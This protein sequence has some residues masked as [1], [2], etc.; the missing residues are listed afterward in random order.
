M[1]RLTP[2][3]E[4]V[5]ELIWQ[6][7]P[8]TP[9]DVQAMYTRPIPNINTVAGAFQS[10][11]RKGYLTHEKKGRGYLYI[12]MIEQKDYGKRRFPLGYAEM[13]YVVLLLVGTVAFAQSGVREKVQ[14]VVNQVV[15]KWEVEEPVTVEE[16]QEVVP[17]PSAEKVEPETE[18]E[19][20]DDTVYE[21]VDQY[22]TFP[23]GEEALLNLL[24]TELRYPPLAMACG[25]SGRIFVSFVIEKDGSVSSPAIYR[26]GAQS[27]YEV[28]GEAV[29]E[30]VESYTPKEG[31]EQYIT[32][33][34][35]ESAR[36]ALE[37]EVLRVVL[38][39]P[40]WNPGELNGKAVR[41]KELFPVTF[42]LP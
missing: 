9:K 33:D 16:P 34:E 13:L 11:E 2:K 29:G 5:M 1:Y 32:P 22:P 28:R 8:C 35:L 24:Q 14:Q 21:V 26:N 3:E 30:R 27:K 6:V 37:T 31:G 15:K 19:A 42:R 41:T 38:N 25:V 36:Q 18:V 40:E 20:E 4:E 17:A 10:L 7:G 12:P 39:M 23:E